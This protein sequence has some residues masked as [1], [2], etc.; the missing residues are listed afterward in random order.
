MTAMEM[1]QMFYD[2]VVKRLALDG[3][4][5]KDVDILT[6]AEPQQTPA[7]ESSTSKTNS[8]LAEVEIKEDDI[9]QLAQSKDQ[10]ASARVKDSQEVE[11]EPSQEKEKTVS[12]DENLAKGA[13]VAGDV[14]MVKQESESQEVEDG[15]LGSSGKE[16]SADNF[17]YS[18]WTFGEMRLL[19]RN[20]LHG[21]LDDRGLMRQVVL[22]SILDY[23]PEIGPGEPGRSAMAG[24][25][26]STWLRDD[27]LVALARVDVS[28]NMFVRYPNQPS[29]TLD[30]DNPLGG[31]FS[32]L[33]TVQIV[34]ASQLRSQDRDVGEWI[35]P[36]MRLIHYVLGKL[37]TLAPGSY[38][39][40][41]KRFDVNASIYRAVETTPVEGE[42]TK[43]KDKGKDKLK[44]KTK[45]TSAQ[46]DLHA[47]H[48]ASPQ[49]L[50]EKTSSGG[51]GVASSSNT[52]GTGE[53]G[54]NS[55]SNGGGSQG[56]SVSLSSTTV[57]DDLILRWVGAQDQIPGTFPYGEP[58]KS[59]SA[60]AK[61]PKDKKR[62]GG[63]GGGKQHRKKKKKLV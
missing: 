8:T 61:V 16:K 10:E 17:E 42:A 24:W 55:N 35:K 29:E 26:M 13:S 22:K 49:V 44:A 53:S 15:F 31:V 32:D 36:S 3:H 37:L 40:S 39:L 57:D 23:A 6:P 41:H 46:Y 38:I 48:Q 28:K 58:G 25:W 62:R 54:S 14:S 60:G 5:C 59:V 20:R 51:G 56:I 30:F 4:H 27:R 1:T 12:L 63:G 18:L 34:D 2:G 47:A 50:N 52:S 9:S 45:T 43:D 11:E 7:D 19:I 33:P 21:F